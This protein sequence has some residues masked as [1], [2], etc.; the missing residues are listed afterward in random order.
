MDVFFNNIQTYIHRLKVCLL[1]EHI[2]RITKELDEYICQSNVVIDET[3]ISRM[4]KL[5]ELYEIDNIELI[6]ILFNH[7]N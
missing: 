2:E 3:Y 1:D 4:Q 5:I 7:R 6:D